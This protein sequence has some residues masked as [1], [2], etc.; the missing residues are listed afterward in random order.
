MD[1]IAMSAAKRAATTRSMNHSPSQR[2]EGRGGRSEIT[3]E[4]QEI[5]GD[6]R[7]RGER[8]IAVT[9]DAAVQSRRQGLFPGP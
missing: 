3:K 5:G 2:A 9:V 1:S 7:R 4:K 8:C 6:G